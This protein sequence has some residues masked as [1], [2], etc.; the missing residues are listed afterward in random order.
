[1]AQ[2]RPLSRIVTPLP[3]GAT[4][5]PSGGYAPSPNGAPILPH[6][7]RT[8]SPL[9]HFELSHSK[10]HSSNHGEIGLSER[11]SSSGFHEPRLQR[12]P[13]LPPT[14]EVDEEDSAIPPQAPTSQPI[15]MGPPSS[16]YAQAP[17]RPKQ[18]PP[19]PASSA[20][21]TLSPS[22]RSASSYQ[23]IGTHQEHLPPARSQTQ[24][25]G[26]FAWR[27]PK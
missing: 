19:P 11:R 8:S 13:S 22:K 14:S 16:R 24:S 18:T 4:R 10:G 12:V 25:P 21:Y 6:Q 15:P 9:A 1:M 17:P 3:P 7:P 23:P 27:V 26:A 20:Q 2:S 5:P